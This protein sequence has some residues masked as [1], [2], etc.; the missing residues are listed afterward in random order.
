LLILVEWQVAIACI[1]GKT[2]LHSGDRRFS[3]GKLREKTKIL[4]NHR[5]RFYSLGD[6]QNF[7]A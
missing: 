2:D 5:L 3:S 1:G 4:S 7:I 6:R